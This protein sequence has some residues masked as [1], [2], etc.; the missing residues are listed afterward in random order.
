MK[1]ETKNQFIIALEGIEL[2]SAQKA[3]INSG[4]QEAIMKEIANIDFKKDLVLKNQ[5]LKNTETIVPDLRPR[6]GVVAKFF[7]EQI[8]VQQFKT[9]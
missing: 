1:I 6:I 3:K 9:N 7:D 5:L 2:S 8:T 4:M